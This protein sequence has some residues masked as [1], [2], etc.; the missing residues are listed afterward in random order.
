M[1]Q[2][3]KKLHYLAQ[4]R[5]LA[6]LALTACLIPLTASAQIEYS[7]W[8]FGYGCGM[9]FDGLATPV[10]QSGSPIHA[11]EGTAT[12][13]DDAGNLLYYT[14][15]LTVW[16]ANHVPMLNGTG[17]W[18][19]NSATQSSL[20]VRKPGSASLHY[21]FQ[22]GNA[23]NADLY[24][25][26][27]DMSLDGGLGGVTADKN[28]LLETSITEKIAGCP[29]QNG[30]DRWIVVH[31]WNS[32]EFNAY[33]LTS[34]GLDTVPVV[35]A[36]GAIHTGSMLHTAGQMKISPN[37][38]KL[39]LTTYYMNRTQLFDFDNSTGLVSAPIGLPETEREYGIGFSPD[40]TKLYTATVLYDTL[41]ARILQYDITSND[42]ML[43]AASEY[44]VYQD[45]QNFGSLEIGLD[46]K[47]YAARY[48][49][50]YLGVINAP[51]EAGA[52]CDYVHNGYWLHDSICWLGLPNQ[53][54][55][56][57]TDKPI[58]ITEADH[59]RPVLVPDPIED[60]G[61]L[62][63]N[64]VTAGRWSLVDALGRV[65]HSDA[66]N[67]ARYITINS[68]GHSPGLYSIVLLAGGAPVATIRCVF[69]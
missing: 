17:L 54:A 57:F 30:I 12:M 16:N 46:G 43:I 8:F 69:Q 1:V 62:H 48:M 5:R 4:M 60:E 55:Y 19:G 53:L 65:V 6:H 58:G 49:T 20:C 26:I 2:G 7:N 39:A 10:F 35:S 3:N 52:L 27:I 33:L 66:T 37:G 59:A 68:R 42:S 25:S 51:N 31:R 67:G 14:D 64:G 41:F 45:T 47:L 61:I 56:P 18:G 34:A 11:L 32:D 21:V 38:D 36:V 24:Y 13:S 23:N 29:H 63:L 44:M 50:N 28:I 40:G 9:R 15:A 22:V